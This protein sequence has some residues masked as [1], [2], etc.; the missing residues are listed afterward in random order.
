VVVLGSTW[1]LFWV[2]WGFRG[3]YEIRLV[4]VACNTYGW[5]VADLFLSE[6][7]E[8]VTQQ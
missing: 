5:I 7:K 1:K 8:L 3:F 2:G 4:G 6:L